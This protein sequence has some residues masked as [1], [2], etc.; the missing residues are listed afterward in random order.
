M[1]ELTR[2]DLDE[3]LAWIDAALKK[4]SKN[5]RYGLLKAKIQ[6]KSS[7]IQAALITINLAHSWAIN[8]KNAN[9]IEQTKLFRQSLL[10]KKK[11]K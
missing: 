3:A 9:Y 1:T 5:F 4:S 7:N 8:A 11:G 10:V 6:D 2:K